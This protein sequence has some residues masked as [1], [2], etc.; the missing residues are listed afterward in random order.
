MKVQASLSPDALE[1]LTQ[2]GVRVSLRYAL[3]LLAPAGILA[4][5]RGSE[6]AVISGNDI[7][8]AT[9]LF[10]D[11]GRSAVAMKEKQDLFI[12]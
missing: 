1:E 8:E 3:Q 5:A 10:W 6:G 9:G 7:K 12:S 4:R 11:A 2:Q